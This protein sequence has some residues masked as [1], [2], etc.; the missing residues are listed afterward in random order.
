[1]K[2]LDMATQTLPGYPVYIAGGSYWAVD[3]AKAKLVMASLYQGI[4]WKW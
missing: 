2:Q 3:P 1:M 4:S